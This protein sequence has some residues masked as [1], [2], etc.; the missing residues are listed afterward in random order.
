MQYESKDLIDSTINGG[1]TDDK[2]QFV[3]NV[4]NNGEKPEDEVRFDEEIISRKLKKL[5]MDKSPGPDG[6]GLHP[7]LLKNC[8]DELSKPLAM[9]FKWSYEQG[10][11]P[12]EWK[13]AHITAIYKKGDKSEPGNYRPVSLASVVCK[14]MESVIK[15]HMLLT[16]ERSGKMTKYQH[17]FTKGRSCLTNLLETFE[18]WTRLLEAGFGIDVIYLDYK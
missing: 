18:A 17:G 10:V 8:A 6:V 4:V 15:D 2:V 14:V 1:R 7:M 16:L 11:L 3:Y 12:E 5:Q 9:L 13:H